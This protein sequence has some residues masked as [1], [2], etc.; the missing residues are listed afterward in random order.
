MWGPPMSRSKPIVA[1]TPALSDIRVFTSIKAAGRAGFDR[2]HIWKAL[3]GRRVHH[4]GLWWA[5]VRV[6]DSALYQTGGSHA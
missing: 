6:R 1:A 5:Y 3:T 2:R 4:A